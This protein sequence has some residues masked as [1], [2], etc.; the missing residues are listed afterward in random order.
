ME[1][2]DHLLQKIKIFSKKTTGVNSKN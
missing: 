1:V 2:C